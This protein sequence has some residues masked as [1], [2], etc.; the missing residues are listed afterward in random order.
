MNGQGTTAAEILAAIRRTHPQ[1]AIVREL[2]IIDET[3]MSIQRRHLL[4]G[5]SG[6]FHRPFIEK[7]ALAVAAELPE[8]WDPEMSR[9]LRR[10]DAL[11]RDSTGYTAIEIKIS[12]GDFKRESPEKRRTWQAHT[13]R[14][15][16]ATPAGLLLPEEIPEECG[17]WE[18][19]GDR[20]KV[21]KKSKTNRQALD[22]PRYVVDGLLYRVSNHENGQP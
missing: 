15:V 18:L 4:D 5:P 8:G 10:I 19:H 17:L 11:M 6:H 20:I 12:R 13:R 22:L 14:F 1:A 9:T 2:G 7:K 16:Y 21:T 3:E